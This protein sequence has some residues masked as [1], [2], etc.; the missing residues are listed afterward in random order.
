M[1]TSTPSKPPS[2]AS[3]AD[4]AQPSVNAAMSAW[5][6]ARVAW[7]VDGDSTRDGAYT[8]RGPSGPSGCACAPWWLSCTNT[9]P[10]AS[11]IAA[12]IRRFA[13]TDSGR[14]ASWKPRMDPLGWTKWLPATNSP[15]PPC[16][17]RT[18]Y[19]VS[20]SDSTRSEYCLEWAVCI[21]RLATSTDPIRNGVNNGDCTHGPEPTAPA[22]AA[23][24]VDCAHRW[25]LPWAARTPHGADA[26]GRSTDG[27]RPIALPSP[28]H[29]RAAVRG[30]AGVCT[31]GPGLATSAGSRHPQAPAR[32][33]A[34]QIQ[35]DPIGNRRSRWTTTW[36]R[37]SDSWPTRSRTSPT[38]ASSAVRWVRSRR[39]RGTPRTRRCSSRRCWTRAS[40]PINSRGGP[41]R[42]YVG[43]AAG[44]RCRGPGDRARAGAATA[45]CG[46]G[47]ARGPRPGGRSHADRRARGDPGG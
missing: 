33:V 40:S 23:D 31:G 42:G 43:T 27:A 11:R 8:G 4:V 45:G 28:G 38:P 46:R 13:A 20:R 47:A 12:V 22:R 32:G 26:D 34:D 2:R 18:K 15:Q 41:G 5:S 30:A 35:D 7:P 24:P 6:I 14:N 29:A 21:S 17:R 39:A 9:R 37:S 19:A 10:P 3:A 1:W 16:A 44:S 25:V 36:R